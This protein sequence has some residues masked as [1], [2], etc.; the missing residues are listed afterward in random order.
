MEISSVKSITNF[1]AGM[2]AHRYADSRRARGDKA[3]P[4]ID[5]TDICVLFATRDDVVRQLVN[6]TPES[7]SSKDASSTGAKT[8]L[9]EKLDGLQRAAEVLMAFPYATPPISEHEALQLLS[10]NPV[11]ELMVGAVLVNAETRFDA[12][13]R[14]G[15]ESGDN[16]DAGVMDADK[17]IEAIVKIVKD[18]KTALMS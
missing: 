14:S 1:E 15:V 13:S 3:Y 12:I 8:V 2:I 10:L 9:R 17:A 4:P 7:S 5:V 16:G 6:T 11:C 18:A